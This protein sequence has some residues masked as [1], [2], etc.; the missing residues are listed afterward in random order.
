MHVNEVIKDEGNMWRELIAL[1][2]TTK[3]DLSWLRSSAKQG[4]QSNRNIIDNI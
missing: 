2:Y 3:R 4:N 1:K